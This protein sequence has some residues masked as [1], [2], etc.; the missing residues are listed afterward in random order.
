MKTKI[1]LLG[2]ALSLVTISCNKDDK[3]NNYTA[4]IAAN[5]V[6]A[7]S[8][9]DNINDDVLYIAESESDQEISGRGVAG[10]VTFLGGC[11]S[12]STEEGDATWI[13]TIDFGAEN[14]MLFN[15]NYVRGKIILTFSADF[16][17]NTRTVSYAFEDFYH[18][19]RKVSGN[20]TV[21]RKILEN[22]HPQATISLDMTVTLTDGTVYTRVGERIRE[23]TAGYNTPFNLFD[24]EFSVTGEWATSIS[25]TGEAYSTTINTPLIIKWNCPHIVSGN[26]TVVRGSDIATAVLDYGAGICDDDATLTI[27]GVVHNITL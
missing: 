17:A 1:L 12:I 10:G 13:R 21:V 27:N 18:N 8:E 15:G 26:V 24:N 7:N 20:R 25:S 11:A 16:D 14:C 2:M 23:F 22:G 19:D 6:K 5:D 4:P 3:E 9:M